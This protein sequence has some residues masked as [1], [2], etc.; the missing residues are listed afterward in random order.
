MT[1]KTERY[2]ILLHGTPEQKAKLLKKLGI[3][4]DEQADS[5]L[6]EQES[7]YS[8]SRGI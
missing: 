5:E 7:G 6:L 4:E 8:R 1:T 2:N 3:K